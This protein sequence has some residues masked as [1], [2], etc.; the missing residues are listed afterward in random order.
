MTHVM[1]TTLL[2]A[3][4]G[5]A[6]ALGLAAARDGQAQS[7]PIAGMWTAERSVWKVR[8]GGTA[9]IVQISMRRRGGGRGSWQSSFAVPLDELRGLSA[10]EIETT[11]AEVRFELPRDAGNVRFEGRFLDGAGAGHFTF[12][13]SE[14]FAAAM[15]ARWGSLDAEKLFALAVHDVSRAFLRDLSALG[16]EGLTFDQAVSLRIH[17]ATPEFVGELR[18]LGYT[19]VPVDQ[20]LSLRIHGATPQFIRDLAALGYTRPPVDQLVSMR[21]HGVSPEFVRELKALGYAGVPVEQLV[22]MRIH[23]VTPEFV[24]R[25]NAKASA[26]A[27]VDRLVNMR[28][29]G[30]E[31]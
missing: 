27:T 11:S 20:L 7:G 15:R 10:S 30:R 28:I 4:C 8:G 22:S 1:R 3:T 24:K 5:A 9:T 17:G 12:A 6:A 23:G 2:V 21:I 25:V 13:P 18:A 29:H 31:P 19:S 16:Y 26:P 14:E